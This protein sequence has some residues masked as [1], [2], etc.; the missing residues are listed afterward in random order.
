MLF[1][2]PETTISFV[3]KDAGDVKL[4]IYNIIGQK[5]KTLVNEHREAGTHSVVWK[6]TDDNHRHVSSGVYLYKMRNGKFSS[7]KKMILMK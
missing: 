4:E 2:S 6:G 7:T 3:L 5:V 1:R